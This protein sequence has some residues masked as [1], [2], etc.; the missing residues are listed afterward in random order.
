M[1][2]YLEIAGLS[3]KEADLIVDTIKD[4]ITDHLNTHYSV[5]NSKSRRNGGGNNSDDNCAAGDSD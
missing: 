4:L 1:K 5:T 2:H 3:S